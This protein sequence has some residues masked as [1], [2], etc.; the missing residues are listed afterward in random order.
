MIS[1]IVAAA[2]ND[3]IGRNSQ[4]V[5]RLP[6]DM[7]RF[8]ALTIGHVVIM[9]KKTY[10]SLGH[11]LPERR[12]IVVTHDSGFAAVGCEVVHSIQEALDVAGKGEVFVIGGSELYKQCWDKADKLYLTRI[13][14]YVEGDVFIPPVSPDDWKEEE[15]VFCKADSRNE[16][17]Y[18]FVTY[19]RK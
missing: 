18:S 8:K 1:L 9:G 13:H 17:D 12:N 6:D 3:V 16:Y 5:W 7:K 4:I 11:A 2:E 19:V 10:K 15:C 14:A